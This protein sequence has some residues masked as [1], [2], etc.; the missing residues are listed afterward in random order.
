MPTRLNLNLTLR[1]GSGPGRRRWQWSTR[2]GL[3][4]GAIER[5][6]NQVSPVHEPATAAVQRIKLAQRVAPG[7][8][9]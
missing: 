2:W 1:L 6:L 3:A 8:V 4:D 5:F 7:S 9:V